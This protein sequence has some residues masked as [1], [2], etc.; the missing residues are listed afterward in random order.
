MRNILIIVSW[1]RMQEGNVK[2][3]PS[4]QSLYQIHESPLETACQV[5]ISL[6]LH[7][8]FDQQLTTSQGS[9]LHGA[10][11]LLE[12]PILSS[13]RCLSVLNELRRGRQTQRSPQNGSMYGCKGPRRQSSGH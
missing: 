5:P 7:T 12:V 13:V 1:G 3:I 9:L 10:T 8:F 4:S 6:H 11:A 2:V